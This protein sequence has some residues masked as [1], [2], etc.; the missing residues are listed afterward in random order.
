MSLITRPQIILVL[1]ASLS[2]CLFSLS[3][4][5]QSNTP[6]APIQPLTPDTTIRG[7]AAESVG[8]SST[9]GTESPTQPQPDTHVLSSGEIFGLGSLRSL[10]H[11]FDPSLQFSQ[12]G[13]TGLVAGRILGVSSLGGSLDL[14]QNWRR[15]HV[16]VA[17]TG[18]DTIYQPSSFGTRSLPYHRLGISQDIF[19][20][21]W[22]LRFRDDAQY[23]SGAAFGGLFTG[24]L[25]GG[26]LS[27]GLPGL[28]QNSVLNSI[29]PL[30]LPNQT[31]ETGPVRQLS[32]TVLGEA[33]YAFSRRTTLTVVGSYSLM[34]YFISGYISSND[35]RGRIGYNYALSAKNNLAVTY[36]HDRANFNG[37]SSLLQSDLVQLAFGRKVTGRLAFQVAAGPEILR[38]HNLGSSNTQQLS[39][40]AFSTVNYSLT[41]NH[42]T[43]LYSHAATS[44]SG[45][46]VGS[47]T[48]TITAGV[49][50]DFTRFWSVSVNG[51]YAMNRNLA[52]VAAFA[53]RFDNGFAGAVVNRELGRQFRWGLSYEF[54]Q[55]SGGAGSCPVPSCGL[56]GSFNQLTV[57][58]QWHPVGPVR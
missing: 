24:G 7:Q 44:G 1:A 45:V 50:H 28:G 18:A 48:D 46:F 8:D 54:Q 19:L 38:L 41:H 13:E 53:S 47:N 52:P 56:A 5:C 30:L 16:A 15:Y 17:Y 35:A 31:I 23:S 40:S 55:Q 37:S 21:R 57:S 12:S 33:D 58:L 36:D 9:Q 51:G 6:D 20:G 42:Y 10:R 3:A 11:V 22:T 32:D 29:Q 26:G 39:W 25:T 43:L 4:R 49:T 14:A 34:R 27:A 2:L